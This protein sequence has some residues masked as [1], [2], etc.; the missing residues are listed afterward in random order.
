M[1]GAAMNNSVNLVVGNDD[2]I[3]QDWE[4]GNRG[5]NLWRTA[6]GADKV[7]QVSTGINL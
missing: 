2:E 6:G 4:V 7:Q 5:V 3:G 1:E